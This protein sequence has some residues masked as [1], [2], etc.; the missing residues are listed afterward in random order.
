MKAHHPLPAAAIFDMDGV[1]VDSNP[2]HLQKW[3]DLLTEHGIAFN[4][5]ELPRLILGSRNDTA[6]RHFF[7]PNITAGESHRLSEELE[8]RFRKAFKPHARPLPGLEALIEEC[9][10]ANLPIALA[11]SAMMKNIEFV[12]DALDFRRFFAYLASGDHVTH[13]KPDPEIYLKA[14]DL[15]GI[16]PRDCIAFEDSFVGVAAACNAGMK[17]VGIASTFPIDE[18]RAQ[19]KAALVVASFEDLTLARLRKLFD[20]N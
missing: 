6:L 14:A 7:G 5:A 18:L 8:A 20:S 10:T 15:L 1:L 9:H 19:T 16:P 4:H 2:F 3:V 17:C 12:V 11:S 13:P